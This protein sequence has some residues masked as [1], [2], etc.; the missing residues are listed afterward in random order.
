MKKVKFVFLFF[1]CSILSC[2]KQIE[3]YSCIEEFDNYVKVNKELLEN[4]TLKDLNV[5]N[6]EKQK[7]SYRSFDSKKKSAIWKE[8]YKIILENANNLYNSDELVE[9]QIIYDF[10]SPENIENVSKVHVFAEEWY[11]RTKQKFSWSDDKYRY[12]FFSLNTNEL[13]YMVRDVDPQP[14]IFCNC[15][16]IH[17]GILIEDCPSI[18]PDC[19]EVNSCEETDGGCGYFWVDKCNGDC[20]F[21]IEPV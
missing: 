19:R 7:A 9:I 11:L 3:C 1:I 16:D 13:A 10:I 6:L 18:M 21:E 20:F 5:L 8:K 17:S 12:L 2:Q 15:N 14:T 4:F